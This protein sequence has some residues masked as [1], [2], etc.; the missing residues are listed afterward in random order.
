MT[1]LKNE[2]FEVIDKNKQKAHE[3]R[4]DMREQL[5][6]FVLNCDSYNL[7]KLYNE[8]KR[9]KRDKTVK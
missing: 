1:E 9:L 3:E 8:F 4:Q 2:H 6:F 5:A 7:M